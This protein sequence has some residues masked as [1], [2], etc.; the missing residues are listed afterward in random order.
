MDFL[1]NLETVLSG[2][3]YFEDHDVPGPLGKV[4][5]GFLSGFGLP[6]DKTA[7]LLTEQLLQPLAS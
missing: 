6:K 5:G 4:D 3:G 1:K 2:D 7:A